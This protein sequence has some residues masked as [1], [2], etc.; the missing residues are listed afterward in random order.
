M[1]MKRIVPTAV[2]VRR[3]LEKVQAEIVGYLADGQTPPAELTDKK[4]ALKAKKEK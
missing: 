2:A 1:A 4:A 3:S